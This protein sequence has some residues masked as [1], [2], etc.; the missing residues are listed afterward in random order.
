MLYYIIAVEDRYVIS[1]AQR[2]LTKAY[3]GWNRLTPLLPLFDSSIADLSKKAS[4]VPH[5]QYT[6]FKQI[7]LR[8]KKEEGVYYCL[9]G[10]LNCSQSCL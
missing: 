2:S 9:R 6:L 8:K 10:F 7:F 3:Q 5:Q 4:V 1:L